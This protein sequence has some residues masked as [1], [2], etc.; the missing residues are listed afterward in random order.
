MYTEQIQLIAS[1]FNI[2]IAVV[3]ALII[4]ITVWSLYWKGRSLWTASKANSLKWFI[5]LLIL[6]TI[7]ILDILYIFYFSKK[8]QKD[9]VDKSI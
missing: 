5:A 4:T 2:P 7:G 3:T 8:G 6:N 9:E 1:T